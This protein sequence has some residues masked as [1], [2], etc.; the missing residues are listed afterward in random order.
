MCH[1]V[2]IILFISSFAYPPCRLT[3]MPKILVD[4]CNDLCFFTTSIFAPADVAYNHCQ[5]IN[6][7][8][9]PVICALP[10]WFRFQQC[11]RRY[12]ERRKR[13]PDVAN[14]GKYAL[15]EAVVVMGSFHPLYNDHSEEWDFFRALWLLMCVAS[16]LYAFA[17]DLMMDWSMVKRVNNKWELRKERMYP[18]VF[19]YYFAIVTNFFLR[20]LWTV[21]IVPFTLT[22][23]LERQ[24]RDTIFL[25]VLYFLEL[26]RRF[27]WGIFRGTLCLI[28]FAFGVL[29]L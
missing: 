9:V 3:S 13:F 4:L 11:M 19:G 8:A 10:L 20:F 17:W 21:N 25:P 29:V 12:Y 16:S 23:F 18:S 14:A 26:Y 28:S 2:S 7:W 1:L 27:Q 6:Y 15:S 22:E 24:G 5:S